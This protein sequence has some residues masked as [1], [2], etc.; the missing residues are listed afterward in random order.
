MLS[1]FNSISG[2]MNRAFYSMNLNGVFTVL[3]P[4]KD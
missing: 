1:K 4:S 3:N 2:L